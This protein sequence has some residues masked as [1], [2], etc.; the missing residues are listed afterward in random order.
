MD[1]IGRNPSFFKFK[2][3]VID[4]RKWIEKLFRP[5]ST[6]SIDLVADS[7]KKA[8]AALDL[9]AGTCFQATV[10]TDG[11]QSFA[12]LEDRNLKSWTIDDKYMTLRRWGLR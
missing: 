10:Y 6:F 1:L 5:R 3:D 11:P 4:D 9:E 2:V 7:I 8:T 12:T